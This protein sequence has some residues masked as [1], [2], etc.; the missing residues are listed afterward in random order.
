[1]AG[2]FTRRTLT[3][4]GCI[5]V[6]GAGAA[7]AGA[8]YY[9]PSVRRAV[10]FWARVGPIAGHYM[11][12]QRRYASEPELQRAEYE[13]LHALYAPASLAVVLELRGLLVKFG[14][15]LSS[16]PELVPHQYVE[17]FRALQTDMPAEPAETIVALIEAELQRPISE[18]FAHFDDRPCGAASIAQAHRART[19]DGREVVVKVQF[20][21]A[22]AHFSADLRG[23]RTLVRLSRPEAMALFDEFARQYVTEL[24]F[25]RERASLVA[26]RAALLPRFAGAVE[27]PL[28]DEE[29]SGGTV[30]TMSFLDGEPLERSVR[31]ALAAAGFDASRAGLRKWLE[32]ADPPQAAA[33]GAAEA[34][35]GQGRIVPARRR[36]SVAAA[37]REGSISP[38]GALV[39]LF[40]LD[41]VLWAYG[42]ALRVRARAL[43]ALSAV[44]GAA[45]SLSLV[46]A[47]QAAE[48]AR[49]SVRA[50]SAVSLARAPALMASLFDVYA[51]EIF[52]RGFFNSDPHPGN[53]LVLS[54]GRLGLIDYGQCKQLARPL[55]LALAEVVVALADRAPDAV[56][57]AAFRKTGFR[58]ER[59][60]DRFIAA[61]ARLMLSRVEPAM[62]RGKHRKE[63]FALDKIAHFPPELTSVWRAVALL[64]GSAL[65]LRCNISP[66]ERWRKTAARLLKAEAE[67]AAEDSLIVVG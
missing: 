7:A 30:L 25:A 42:F 29:R 27:V 67:A 48:L 14:Q 56:V 34:E 32:S 17:A 23:L 57:A 35:G 65:S 38:R 24:D 2:F 22:A 51:F 47:E 62:M 1:M 58:S 50:A 54:D 36:R 61:I 28:L 40:G 15:Q 20:P 16:R 45:A 31:A 52:E 59:D 21:H 44:A 12:A 8:Y 53:V 18:L 26:M 63:L 9:D 33:A 55:R 10:T 39:R 46:S 64:R 49:A 19:P 3:R 11:Y 37:L 5:A 41:S 6:G 66:A 43:A 4:V 13:R 60:D